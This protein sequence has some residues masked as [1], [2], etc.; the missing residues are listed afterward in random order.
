MEAQKTETAAVK[1]HLQQ[2][3]IQQQKPQENSLEVNFL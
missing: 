1:K 3:K 2:M